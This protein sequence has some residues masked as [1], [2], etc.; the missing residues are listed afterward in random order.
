MA[1]LFGPL[2]PPGIGSAGGSG[3]GVAGGSR[4]AANVPLVGPVPFGSSGMSSGS[5]APAFAVGSGFNWR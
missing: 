3:T 2:L 1:D 5:A 4:K